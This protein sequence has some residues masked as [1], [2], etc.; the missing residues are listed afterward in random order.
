MKSKNNPKYT[1]RNAK[2]IPVE[3]RYIKPGES[4]NIILNAAKNY[5]KDGDFLIISET[6]VSISQRRLVDESLFS[7]SLMAIFL[8]DVWSK[9]IWGHI[10]GPLFRIKKRTIHNLRELPP[11]SRAHKEVVLQYYGLKHAL[12]PA[13][14]AGIDLSNVPGSMVSLLPENPE[15]VAKLLSK[16]IKSNCSKDITVIIIDTDATYELGGKKFTC[17]PIAL[18]GIKEDLGILGY[19]MGKFGHTIGPTPLGASH[20]LNVD[21]A[22]KLAQIAENYQ[23]SVEGHLE[24]VYN[25]K[26]SFKG[27][28]DNVSIE[29]LESIKHTPAIIIRHL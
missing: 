21:Y 22:L 2:V 1:I 27:E 16:K 9:L 6:P 18:S 13:S 3:T 24:T 7:P 29:M 28:I 25:M 11:E 23:K 15:N 20:D 19:I 10:L 4:L 8:A 12:K 17:L 14:E 26:N 5:L